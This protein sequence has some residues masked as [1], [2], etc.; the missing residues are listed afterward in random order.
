MEVLEYAKD[1]W[2]V[3]D[4]KD[5]FFGLSTQS[6]QEM[7]MMPQCAKVPNSPPHIRGVINLRGKILSLVDLRL[8]LGMKSLQEET[9][10]LIDLMKQREQDHRN[11][12]EQL[13]QSIR[14]DT[15][16]RLTLDP[17]EC[18]FGKWYDN[19][20]TENLIVSQ[21]LKK[22]DEPHKKIH[23]LGGEAL[24]LNRQGRHEEAMKRVE[25]EKSTTLAKLFD[26]FREFRSILA[27]SSREIAVVVSD[28][29]RSFAVSVDGVQSVERLQSESFK[30][31]SET[32]MELEHEA[33]QVSAR[34]QK[35]EEVVLILD[36][37]RI[38]ATPKAA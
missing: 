18:K 16:F 28:G 6:V 2:L 19:F 14:D 27:E 7:V 12:M 10:S 25:Q 37:S 13:E 4:L 3:A 21:F 1:P 31:L 30:R 22:F 5:Q 35:S 20:H 15:P 24:E 26:L 29:Q 36:T 32:G 38:L 23:A 8:L 11:W 33:V 34:R 9:S 17:H